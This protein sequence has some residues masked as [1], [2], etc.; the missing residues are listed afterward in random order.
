MKMMTRGESICNVLK[1]IRK[2]VADA[3]Q[4]KYQPRECHHQGECLGTC[5]ACEAE[6]RY[7][8]RQLD[9]R[10]QLGKAVTI[11]GISAGLAA[12]TSCS[13]KGKTV[14]EHQ[15]QTATLALQTHLLVEGAMDTETLG[16]VDVIEQP[17]PPVV[18]LVPDEDQYY[19]LVE[20]MP[21]FPGGQ[22]AL[23][24]FVDSVMRYPVVAQEHCLQGRV[25]VAFAVEKDGSLTDIKVVK[26]VDP[27]LDR[28]ALRIVK[29]MP[30]W[31]PGRQEGQLMRVKY[32]IPIT[33][34]PE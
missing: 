8:Q 11:I 15:A 19:D 1:T 24:A 3:N 12:L 31:I 26:S 9:I 7:I 14:V 6:V 27:S 34:Q 16:A 18:G 4:I 30:R 32:V 29:M 17:E 21:S 2:Q 20:E 10:R 28:E 23:Q 33:F 5:P 25:V 22:K 13:D